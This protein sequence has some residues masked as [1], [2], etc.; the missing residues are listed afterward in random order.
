MCTFLESLQR[1]YRDM[2]K[3]LSHNTCQEVNYLNTLFSFLWWCNMY[4]LPIGR[5][6]LIVLWLLLSPPPVMMIIILIVSFGTYQHFILE[7]VNCD[8][9][10]FVLHYLMKLLR[11]LDLLW[12]VDPHILGIFGWVVNIQYARLSYSAHICS[13]AYVKW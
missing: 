4:I 13:N 6:E 10:S 11:V 5:K 2:V 8:E 12:C 7:F 9:E 1:M 3:R